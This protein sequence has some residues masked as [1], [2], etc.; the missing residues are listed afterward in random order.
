M[1]ITNTGSTG[2]DWAI[3]LTT[4][5]S[6]N[7]LWNAV[8]SQSGTRLTASGVSWNKTLAP[9]AQAEFGYCATR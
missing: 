7:N 3:Q 8:W 9:G 1:L 4:R 2:G 5:G 6:I